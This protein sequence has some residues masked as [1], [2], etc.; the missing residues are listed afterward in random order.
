MIHTVGPNY[1][2]GQRDRSLLESCYRRCLEVADGL[3]A[4]SIALPLISAGAYGWPKED[5]IAAAVDTLRGTPTRVERA[6]IVA[7]DA[8][9]WRLI[10]Q[11]LSPGR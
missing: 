1:R 7:F 9:T 10:S 8:D 2:S 11:R 4:R 5:A 3:G 6:T